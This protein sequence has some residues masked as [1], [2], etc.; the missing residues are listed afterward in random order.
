MNLNQQVANN[1]RDLRR[2]KGYSQEAMSCMLGISLNAYCNMERGNTKLTIEKL[3]IIATA[4][5]TNIA[6]IMNFPINEIFPKIENS[7][8]GGEKM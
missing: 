2:L 6:N 5:E 1:I 4:L 7:G 8:G 3:E